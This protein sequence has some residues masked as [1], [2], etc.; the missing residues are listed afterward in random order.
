[1][2]DQECVV[3]AARAADRDQAWPLARDLATSFRPERSAFDASFGTL[4]ADPAALPS[5]RRLPAWASRATCSRSA[6][7]PST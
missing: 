6:T 4:L 2:A 1:M 5:S 7:P 3:R